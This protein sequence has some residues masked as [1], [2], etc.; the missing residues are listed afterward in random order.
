[1]TLSR[2]RQ[3]PSRLH[4][5]WIIVA[6]TFAA[7]VVA[8]GVRATPSVLIVPLEE[9]FHWSRA[10]ISLAIGINLLLYGAIGPFAAAIMDR[11]GARRTLTLALAAAAAAVA[12]TP[13][14]GHPWLFVLLWGV[15]VG[16]STGF[17][18]GY[19]AAF[20][21]ATWFRAREGLVVGILTAA[22]AAGQIVSCRQWRCSSSMS[23][24]VSCRWPW[25]RPF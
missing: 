20:I 2:I 16:L 9:K 22:N 14:M 12:L 13:T 5:A 17:L 8:A 25:R 23:A 10:V 4:Y 7:V 19:L 3:H 6:V 1:M 21:A 11:F 18:G 15:I 24:G